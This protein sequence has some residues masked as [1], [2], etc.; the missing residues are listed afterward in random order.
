MDIFIEKAKAKGVR[1]ETQLRHLGKTLE[2]VE[3]KRAR[4][5]EEMT[6]LEY[7]LSFWVCCKGSGKVVESP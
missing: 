7:L 3:R 6:H 1:I 2:G 5:R 4:V